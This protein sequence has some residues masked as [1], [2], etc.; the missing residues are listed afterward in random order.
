MLDLK[1]LR[2]LGELSARG[3]I[4]AVAEALSSSPSA[5]SQQLAQL[6]REAGVP[7]LEGSAATCG[8]RRRRR[9][10]SATPTRCSR[11]SRADDLL[12]LLAL[13]AAGQ[14]VHLVRADREPSVAVRDVA[15]APLQRTVFGAIRRGSGR[16]PALNAL[17]AALRETAADLRSEATP[18]P[19]SRQAPTS[20]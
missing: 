16:R 3:T 18:A 11:A 2:L 19:G 1:R 10:S 6:E 5:A 7:L 15:A 4:G 20:R 8:S 9:R 17:R 13:V 14:A 12:M